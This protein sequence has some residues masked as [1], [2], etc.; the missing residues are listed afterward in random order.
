MHNYM[1][2]VGIKYMYGIFKHEYV[3]LQIYNIQL[4]R[5]ILHK[6]NT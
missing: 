5:V 4:M 6:Q 3:I 1:A 2:L